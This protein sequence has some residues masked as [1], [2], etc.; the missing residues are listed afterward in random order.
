MKGYMIFWCAA[1][2]AKFLSVFLL[3]NFLT[4][5]SYFLAIAAIL[6]TVYQLLHKKICFTFKNCVLIVCILAVVAVPAQTMTIGKFHLL[7]PLYQH[8]AEVIANDLA[9]RSSTY[10]NSCQAQIRIPER[11]LLN[12]CEKNVECRSQ[13]D[14]YTISFT[15][16]R[17]FFQWYAYVYFSDTIDFVT[18]PVGYWIGADYDSIIWIE[19][20]QWALVK[21]Y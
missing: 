1:L 21:Y 5:V 16:H 4:Y 13:G 12:N 9:E 3:Q 7:K 14:A 18:T 17:D 15:K 20:D 19:Q 6:F 8:S 11:I 2:C 10:Y